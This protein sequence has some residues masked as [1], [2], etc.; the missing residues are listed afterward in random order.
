MTKIQQMLAAGI[1]VIE[2][3]SDEAIGSYMFFEMSDEQQSALN[4]IL[5]GYPVSIST[6]SNIIIGDGADE[7]LLTVS[8]APDTLVTVNTLAGVTAGTINIQLDADG[9]GSQVFS[10]ETSPTVI[11]FSLGESVVKVRA[12]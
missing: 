9:N 4:G 11:V 5:S 12:L 1:P 8:G 6:D 10:C 3:Q 2:S 7:I